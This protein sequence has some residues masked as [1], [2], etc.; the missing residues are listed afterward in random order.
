MTLQ[1]AT[2]L[3]KECADQMNARYKKT[4]FD[5]WAIISLAQKKSRILNYIGPRNDDFLKNFANDLGA[6]RA[7]L[8]KDRHGV[9]D[10]EFTRH[11]VGTLFEAFVVLGDGIYLICNNTSQTMEDIAKHPQ[12]LEAQKPFVEFS[13]KV[14]S[15]PLVYNL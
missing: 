14:R 8:V 13:D 3:I 11:G 2:K 5:E 12:W 4:V 7:E 6:L 9:G 15:S 10:F 1:E